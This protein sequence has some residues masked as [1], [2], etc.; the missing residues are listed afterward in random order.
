[1]GRVMECNV[2]VLAGCLATEAEHRT[3]ST[4]TTQLRL[5]VTTR[6]P[7]PNRRVHVIPVTLWDPP[8]ALLSEPL[9][10]G[11]RVYVFGTVQRRFW[12]PAEGPRGR[13]EVVAHVVELQPDPNEDPAAGGPGPASGNHLPCPDASNDRRSSIDGGG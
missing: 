9:G 11:T 3:F 7:P 2:V 12:P 1:M 4:G 8:A 5:L 6:T 10:R 13:V